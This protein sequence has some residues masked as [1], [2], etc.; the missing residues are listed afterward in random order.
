M[1]H[2]GVW[3]GQQRARVE[4]ILNQQKLPLLVMGELNSGK[5]TVCNALLGE[6]VF[7][8]DVIPCTSRLTRVQ[9]SRTKW[10]SLTD[11]TTDTYVWRGS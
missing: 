3:S 6:E 5:S 7:P 4:K 8:H 11:L 9:Y 2:K 1:I 10:Y